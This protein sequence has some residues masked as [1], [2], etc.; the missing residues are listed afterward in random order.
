MCE[1]VNYVCLPPTHIIKLPFLYAVF[2]I[3]SVSSYT[4]L[5]LEFWKARRA[6][7]ACMCPSILAYG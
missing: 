3:N 7:G 4:S 1:A 6:E 5:L 2:A